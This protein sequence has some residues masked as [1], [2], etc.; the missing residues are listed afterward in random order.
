MEPNRRSPH[1]NRPLRFAIAV[2]TSPML[3]FARRTTSLRHMTRLLTLLLALFALTLPARAADDISAAS[4]SVVRVVTVAMMD[5]EVVGFGHGSG[6]MDS[7]LA[8]GSS[9]GVGGEYAEAE[10]VVE[11]P[12]V[13]ESVAASDPQSDREQIRIQPLQVERLRSERRMR[14]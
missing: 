9:H 3:A 6:L 13:S 5:G 11:E 14:E 12:S 2:Q 10:P 1:R 7:S 4:R 8:A